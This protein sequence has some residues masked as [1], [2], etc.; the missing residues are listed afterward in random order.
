MDESKSFKDFTPCI[1]GIE[2]LDG[3]AISAR[4]W[5][6]GKFGCA[7]HD[8]RWIAVLCS[9]PSQFQA[10]FK[11][12]NNCLGAVAELARMTNADRNEIRRI[13]KEHGG[14]EIA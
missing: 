3:F 10:Y 7:Q 11:S 6:M 8:G 2:G 5:K 4:G 12:Q 13:L 14:A 1:L 9:D